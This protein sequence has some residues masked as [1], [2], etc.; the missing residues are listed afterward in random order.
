MCF[1]AVSL[2]L[3]VQGDA[4]G[5][6][7]NGRYL[8]LFAHPDDDV[9][10][11]GTMKMLIDA[12]AEVHGAWLGSGDWLGQGPTRRA[13]RSKAAKIM[14][15]KRSRTHVLGIADMHFLGNLEQAARKTA[16]LFSRI[17][18]DIVFVP[19]YEGGHPD[20]DAVNFLAYEA[21][22]R[23]GLRPKLFEFPLYN[24]TG[25]AY[26][27]WWRVN[28]FP[29]GGPAVFSTPL[30]GA[31]VDA[32]FEII[33]TYSSQWMLMIPARLAFSRSELLEVGELYRPCPADR[34]HTVRP[35]EDMLSYERW[36]NFFLGADFEDFRKAVLKT[37][38]GH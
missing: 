33:R 28:D 6:S 15:L 26:H 24:A 21:S 30:N 31:A 19:A 13:E 8:F 11:C 16:A 1:V 18:P 25:P 14:G 2:G 36:F 17:K 34:D 12:G 27:W 10:I 29:P 3:L 32:K 9:M 38:R 35:H 20:H 37:R 7:T 5:L 4:V 23:T 22:R